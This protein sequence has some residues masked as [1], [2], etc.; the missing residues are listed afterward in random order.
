MAEEEVPLQLPFVE[1]AVVPAAKIL[2][3]LF[4]SRS[5]NDKSRLMFLMG[6]SV[7][8]PLEVEAA[9]LQ[10]VRTNPVSGTRI[11]SAGTSYEIRGPMATPVGQ[12]PSIVSVWH[13][14][15]CSEVPRFVTVYRYKR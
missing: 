12:V 5:K 8:R 15:R 7:E 1:N 4:V 6:F 10:H 14:D 11:T 13:I 3:Y 9:L 2:D